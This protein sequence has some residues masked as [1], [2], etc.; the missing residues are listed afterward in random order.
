M[1]KK[2]L[3]NPLVAIIVFI[4]S[5][6]LYS[7]SLKAQQWGD[8][9]LYSVMGSST[10]KLVDTTSGV[11]K[12]WT[13][14]TSQKTGYSSYLLPGGTLL[15]TVSR[16]G[17]S[18]SGGPIC[19][20]VMKVDWSGSIIWDFIYSTPSYCSH[21]DVCPMP[22][23]NVLMISYERKTAA[24]VN[25]AGCNTFTSEMWPDKIVEVQPTGA[26]TGTI[27]WEWHAWDH[28]VQ[29][30]DATK[31]NYQTSIVNH[32][33]LLNI[34]YNATKDWMHMN[35]VDYNPILDQVTF[36]S[37]NLSEIYVIDHST[38]TA[39]AASHLGGNSGKGGDLLYRWGHPAVY[40]ATG[41][42]ILNVVHDAHWIPEGVPNAGYLV[43]FNNNGISNNQSAVDQASP[44]V[45]GYNYNLTVGQA[46]APTSFTLRHAC[47]GHSSNMGNSQQLPNG[48]M[49]VCVATAGS[50]YELDPSGNSIWTFST[51]GNNAKAF[52]YN[53]CY[54]NNP[55]PPI[56]VI[57]Q[58]GTVLSADSGVTFQWYMN[59]VLLAGETNQ[60]YS[61]TQ[62]GIYLVR[63][64]DANGCDYSYSVGFHYQAPVGLSQNDK[65]DYWT[66]YPN[67]TNG[68][69]NIAQNY[70]NIGDYTLTVFDSFG[71][72][73]VHQKNSLV[74]DL[75][76]QS[77]GVYNLVIRSEVAATINSKI[78]LIK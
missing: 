17:N 16:S 65:N 68:L 21:H 70:F 77:N 75:S 14:T 5:T 50:V 34:N 76:H 23:G 37:H 42:Q 10:A 52:R 43:G 59:G 29:N 6:V 31:A 12:T 25:A 39:E 48:N 51:G 69:I 33:E 13:F 78:V 72:L 62:T 64:T 20:E 26:T 60:N 56:P 45:S 66:V 7:T 53:T 32:P 8:Y 61:P 46:Y 19:G 28:L 35:G 24:E 3:L 30:V 18:F 54:I 9:T 36:S 4:V 11:F 41:S 49:L 22:N 67:P 44:P 40:S 47:N 38:T 55:A 27:V 71:K 15:R 74:I 57:T 2:K 1:N 73:I 63:I 58:S